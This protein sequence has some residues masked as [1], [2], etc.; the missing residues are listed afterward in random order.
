VKGITLAWL[1]TLAIG[2]YRWERNNGSAVLP[3]PSLYVGAAVTF[4]VL[5][6]ASGVAPKPAA[7]V[8]WGFVVAALVNP[9]FGAATSSKTPAAAAVGRKQ[10]AA[11]KAAVTGAATGAAKGRTS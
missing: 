8:A 7:I 3:P 11:S 2:T 1:T 6:L 9:Q 4:S 10:A 5:G